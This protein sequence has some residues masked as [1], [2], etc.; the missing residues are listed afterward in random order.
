MGNEIVLVGFYLLTL[1]YSVIIHEVSHGV[2]AL[3]LGDMTAKYAGRLNLNPA[4][5]ID[6]FGSVILPLL[7]IVTT[8]FAFGWA[9][10]VP[11]NP[12]NLRNQKWG[13]TMVALAGPASNFL[14]AFIAALL[15]KLLPLTML[16]KTDILERF[17][18]VVG[19]RGSFLDRFELFADALSGSLPSIFFGLLLLVIFWNV[20][21]G[22][23]NLLPVP[24]LDGSKLL[25]AL[26]QVKEQTMLLL[27][28]YGLFILIFIIFFA[29]G[30]ISIFINFV[31]SL[32]LRFTL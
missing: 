29:S 4:K 19:G 32:F 17:I 1:I 7:L 23:F 24:P 18:G 21:L 28:Q 25:Y 6:P 12:Y 15:A 9:K 20:V 14:L 11:Y 13:S 26:F 22:C 5:H 3:W 10:P 8:G 30:P 16:A 27:E 31:L 2:V